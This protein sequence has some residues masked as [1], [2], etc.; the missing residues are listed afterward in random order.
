[1]SDAL[2]KAASTA[3]DVARK[4]KRMDRELKLLDHS[5][6]ASGNYTTLA[7]VRRGWSIS[8]SEGGLVLTICESSEATAA[9]LGACVGVAFD[10]KVYKVAGSDKVRPIGAPLVWR[11]NLT[12]TGESY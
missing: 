3:L 11:F 10:G 7:G 5:D 8:Q 6:S 1:M 4:L 2:T 9:R 12:G